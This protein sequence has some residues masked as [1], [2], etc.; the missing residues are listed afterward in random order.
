MDLVEQALP[1]QFGGC[2]LDYQ[3]VEDEQDGVPTV[4]SWSVR[5]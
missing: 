3:M 5:A 2:A 1:A 4:T